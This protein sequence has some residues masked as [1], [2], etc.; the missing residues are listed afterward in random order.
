[1]SSQT[2]IVSQWFKRLGNVLL[3]L[4]YFIYA[5]ASTI[6]FQTFNCQ[7]IDSKTFLRNDLSIDCSDPAHKSATAFAAIMVILFSVGLPVIYLMLLFPHRKGFA[8]QSGRSTVALADV[9]MLRFFYSKPFLFC[10]LSY[11]SSI[12]YTRYTY[13]AALI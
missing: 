8:G 11:L 5:A 4:G 12:I 7:Q 3:V 1:M 10:D 9:Q 6:F 2:R 13:A